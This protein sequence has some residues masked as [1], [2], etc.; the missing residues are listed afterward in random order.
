[1][2][3]RLLSK[4]KQNPKKGKDRSFPGRP[5]AVLEGR[6]APFLSRG[7][8][9]RRNSRVPQPRSVA[10]G[11]QPVPS[12]GACARARDPGQP[13]L[14]RPASTSSRS[15]SAAGPGLL[16]S[17]DPGQGTLHSPL[18]RLRLAGPC[19][20]RRGRRRGTLRG[21]RARERAPLLRVLQHAR[22]L[23]SARNPWNEAQP[24]RAGLLLAGIATPYARPGH[25]PRARQ[26]GPHPGEPAGPRCTATSGAYP[27]A[28]R[29]RNPELRPRTSLGLRCSPELF[30]QG[31]A[32]GHG[33][34]QHPSR[35]T[36][37]SPTNAPFRHTR[38][39]PRALRCV[40]RC[41][42]PPATRIPKRSQQASAPPSR[43]APCPSPRNLPAQSATRGTGATFGDPTWTRRLQPEGRRGGRRPEV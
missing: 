37:P 9:V 38:E 34:P 43:H 7:Q 23:G 13:E 28:P 35:V 29:A 16:R 26:V 19:R 5:H 12:F 30:L 39:N 21:A 25:A 20:G 2:N 1:M 31:R 36:P 14:D 3:S 32:H 10:A 41:Q 33:V 40:S 6:S 22:T 27:P 18:A 17:P 24:A 4:A 8:E 11:T 15:R 42:P